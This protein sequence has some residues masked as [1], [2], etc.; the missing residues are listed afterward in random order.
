ML[1]KVL[2]RGSKTLPQAEKWVFEVLPCYRKVTPL[3]N[4]RNPLL[5]YISAYMLLCY[6][7]YSINF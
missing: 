2:P 5:E 3:G 6:S 7:K 4:T 1:K